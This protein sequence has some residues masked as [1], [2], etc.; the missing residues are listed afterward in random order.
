MPAQPNLHLRLRMRQVHLD[1]HNAADIP[2]VG[3]D[4]DAR[5]FAETVKRAHI[6]SM[7]VFS[8]CH[9]GFSYHPTQVG[10]M[11]PSLIFDLL[12]AQ[13]EALHGIGARAPIY[14]SVG[15]DELAASEHPEWLQL[16]RNGRIDGRGP[17]EAMGWRS[18]DYTGP[19]GDYVLAQTEEVLTRY[20]PVDG[21]F[22]DILRPTYEG[23]YSTQGLARLRGDGVD[24][25]DTEQVLDW[26]TRAERDFMRRAS[27]LVRRHNPQATIFFNSRLRPDR[28]P[29]VSTRAELSYFTH[30]EI[31]SLPSVVWGYHHYPLFAA[32]FQTLGVPLLGMTGIFHKSWGDFGG[33]KP[34][35]ALQYECARMLASGAACSI[36]DQ[37]HPRGKLGAATY[38][39]IG[40][41][42]ARVE[43]LEP[44]TDGAE[45]VREIG[46]LLAETGARFRT[47][48]RDV[49]EGAMR[50]MMELHRPYQFIDYEADFTR[51]QAIIA[52]DV[53]PFGPA[54]ADKMRAYLAQ[55]G[56]LLLTHRAGLTP[57]G[58]AFA[59]DIGVDYLDDAPYNPD[60]LVAGQ[61]LPGRFTAYNQVL[62]ERG[63][64]VR[65]RVGSTVLASVGVPYFNRTH[66]HFTSHAH[67]PFDRV[68]DDPAIV[69]SGRIIY[70]HSPLFVAYRRHAVPYYRDLIGALL[71]RLA[72][73]R[74]FVAPNLPTTAEIGLLR[75]SAQGGRYVLH[76]LHAVPQRRGEN[77]ELVEDVLPLYNVRVGVRME[78]PATDV[79]LAPDGRALAHETVEG[80]TWVTVPEV[81]GHQ[82][83]VFS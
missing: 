59:L 60:F 54:L 12:G 56:A 52:P 7:T 48:G 29:A 46:V 68:S 5:E 22:F 16:D 80:I 24:E 27:D 33:L 83:V 44:W 18:L 53:V 65:A 19:Y 13:I 79:S 64:R 15:W 47:A 50:M 30:V 62:Y 31:E 66:R 81:A 1:A 2:D 41:V 75:Q 6:N 72:P 32:Y 4:F 9:H 71:D 45:P 57:D 42:Y 73:D 34:E 17:L 36:G 38:E 20:A 58:K 70:C 61:Q 77:L 76:L 49:D 78:Q 39:R 67:T 26:A 69:Q 14:I 21:I 25:T 23:V 11:H 43:A 37:V 55:G 10:K 51:Y 3:R 8:K 35:A 74:V 40:R 63:S 82:V 28:D